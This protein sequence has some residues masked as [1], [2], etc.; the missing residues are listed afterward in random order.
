MLLKLNFPTSLCHRLGIA[1]IPLLLINGLLWLWAF[2]LTTWVSILISRFNSF[3]LYYKMSIRIV[4]CWCDYHGYHWQIKLLP[5]LP[6]YPAFIPAKTTA[7]VML[8]K[9]GEQIVSITQRLY[10]TSLGLIV[11]RRTAHEQIMVAR[12]CFAPSHITS[13]SMLAIIW[14]KQWLKDGWR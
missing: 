8:I 5:N 7:I 6:W 14:S 9:F 4:K 10:T 12:T 11:R 13:V 1:R 2:D 3:E